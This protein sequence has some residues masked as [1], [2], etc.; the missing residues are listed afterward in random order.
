M[1]NVGVGRQAKEAGLPSDPS[2]LRGFP[3]APAVV[4]ETV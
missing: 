4:E 2:S 1:R 3:R